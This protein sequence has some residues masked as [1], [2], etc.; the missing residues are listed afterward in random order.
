[1]TGLYLTAL[2]KLKKLEDS[3]DLKNEIIRFPEVYETLCRAFQIKKSEAFE[4]LLMFQD[5]GFI[6]IVPYNGIK[7][8]EKMYRKVRI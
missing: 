7:I 8:N 5:F 1:M 2:Q 6:E 4:I 3:T